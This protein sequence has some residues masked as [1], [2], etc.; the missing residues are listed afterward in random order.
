SLEQAEN[1]IET[2]RNNI[3]QLGET[4][5]DS[6]VALAEPNLL[7]AQENLAEAE[8]GPTVEEM[9]AAQAAAQAAWAR[10]EELQEQPTQAQVN[11]ALASLHRAE[12][13]VAAAQREYD[14][15]A[16]LPESSAS[17]AADALQRATID[18]EAAKAAFD[19][20]NRPARESELQGA[21][22]SAQ[23]AQANLNNLRLL[24]TAAQI[25]DAEARLASAE[26]AYE[27]ALLGPKESDMRIGE[28][29]LRQAM[30]G[31]E[32]ARLSLDNAQVVA[33][34]D[35]T[36]MSVEVD[37]GQQASAGTVVATLADPLDVRLVVNVEQRDIR[38][39]SI[40]QG[41]EIS[42]YA[43]PDA[44]FLGVVDKIAP[45]AGSGT[46]FVTFPVIIELVDGPLDRI[47]PGMTASASFLPDGEAEA[48]PATEENVA[49]EDVAEEDVTGEEAAADDAAEE[50]TAADDTTGEEPA[51]E[52]ATDE[53]TAT[54]ETATEETATEETADE[55]D[56]D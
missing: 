48:T 46:G 6:D 32:Q 3:E 25:A 45:I 27:Q 54:E 29:S 19:E 30:I 9:A 24:P 4:V 23:S 26:A 18:L 17:S 41:V 36:V 51:A 47:L 8:Q 28:L 52:D 12:I 1:N 10:Y 15:I 55:S 22:S 37:L 44:V 20:V 11:Q 50:D 16:W 34:I 7:L 49:E 31:L 21:L 56:E 5:L 39:V 13:N 43:L 14:K 40:G 33:P 42:I 2:A 53:E 35:G 38:M